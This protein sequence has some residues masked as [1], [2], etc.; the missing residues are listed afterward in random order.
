ML[1]ADTPLI[2]YS[3]HKEFSDTKQLLD[4]SNIKH[5]KLCQYAK[6]AATWSTHLPKL[7][8]AVS[9]YYGCM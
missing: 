1:F 8:F 3:S 4:A 5:E 7:E 2:T 6:E 9:I